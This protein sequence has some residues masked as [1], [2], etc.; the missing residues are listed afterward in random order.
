MEKEYQL[1][2]SYIKRKYFI[3][4]A[5]RRAST[6]EEMWYFETIVWEWDNE[7]RKQGKMLDME[8]SGIG[9]EM[10]FNNHC[11]LIKKYIDFN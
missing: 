9:E 10:A 7:T 4:T 5:F 11:R 2:C 3:S 8:D 6:M 1:I